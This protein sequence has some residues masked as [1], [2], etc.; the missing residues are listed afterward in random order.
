MRASYRET[1]RCFE[2]LLDWATMMDCSFV[3]KNCLRPVQH[4]GWL[5]V[6]RG[7]GGRMKFALE[8]RSYFHSTSS[9]A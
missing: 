7:G 3:Y 9:L 6:A 1:C 2:M 4:Q 8:I 5:I